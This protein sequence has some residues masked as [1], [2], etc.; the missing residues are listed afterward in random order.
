MND[1]LT[2]LELRRMIACGRKG[3]HDNRTGGN[4]YHL[5]ND[6]GLMWDYRREHWPDALL[7]LLFDKLADF[8]EVEGEAS[9]APP[10]P[11][12]EPPF[13]D[14]ASQLC[15]ELLIDTSEEGGAQAEAIIC[16]ALRKAWKAA[17]API[18]LAGPA[19]LSTPIP[20]TFEAL[21]A[22]LVKLRDCFALTAQEPE[23]GAGRRAGTG[24][25]WELSGYVDA[26]TDAIDRINHHHRRT[27][28][29]D[30]QIER[31][32][33]STPPSSGAAKKENA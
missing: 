11:P 32:K 4:D 15:E 26:L 3:A 13:D 27:L 1:R 28:K 29:I 6:C 31:R 9:V 30:A 21:N 25:W 8:Q 19:P 33:L 16:E 14:W 2:V 24:G 12:T 20:M 23:R 7:N 18:P 10:A 22:E 17:L 5:C